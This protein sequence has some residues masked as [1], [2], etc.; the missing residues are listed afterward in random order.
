MSLSG[1]LAEERRARLAA[2]RLLEQ[3]QAE[4]FAANRKLGQHARLL[5]EQ[6]VETRAEVATVRDENQRVKS[7]LTKANEKIAIVE[8][9][10]WRALESVRDGFA[11]FNADG[12]LELANPAYLSVFDGVE[13][14][15]PGASFA[16]IVDVMIEEGIVDLRGESPLAWRERLLG[17]WDREDIPPEII[18]LWNG[19]FVKLMDRRTPDGG[20]V[21]LAVNITELMRMWSAVEELPDGFVV[22]DAEDRLVTCNARYREL[23]AESAEAMVPGASFEE[24]LRHGLA[25]RQFAEALGRE[26]AWLEERLE[27]HRAAETAI[28][29]QLADGRWLRI[30][31]KETSDGGRV[32]LRVDITHL[33]EQQKA[34]EQA[35]ERAEAANR[36]KSAFL[37]NMTHEIRTPMNGVVGMA[38]LLANTGLTEDQALYVETIRT[39]GES[40]LVII[41][42]VLDYSKIEADKLSLHP[43]PFDLERCIH[44]IVMLLQPTARD[45]GLV[46]LVDYDLFLPTRFVGDPGRIR[47]VLTNLIGN[48]VKFTADGHVL[49]RVTGLPD[50]DSGSAE[51]IVTV[52]DT[53][54]GIAADRQEHIFGEFNQVE[55]ACNRSFEG[56]GLGLA[57]TRR[58]IDLM[59][60]QIWVE[61]EEGA[62]ACFGFRVPLPAAEPLPEAPMGPPAMRTALVVDDH[63]ANREILQKQL[64]ALGMEVRCA[65]SAEVAMTLMDPPPDV[66]LTDHLMPGT[67]GVAFARQ[68][69]SGGRAMPILLLSS[70]PAFV[71]A[72]LENGLLQ[73]ILQKPVPRQEL[74]RRLHALGGV[75]TEAPG[76]GPP[77]AEAPPVEVRQMRVLLAE[78]NRTNQLVFGKMVQGLDIDLAFAAN[79]LEAVAA[80]AAGPPDLIFMDISMPKMDGRAAARE[81]R[82]QEA[83][84][85]GR[86]PIV[87]VTAHAMEGD[88]QAILADGID[89]YISKPVRKAALAETIRAH[90][91][92]GTRPPDPSDPE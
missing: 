60:G 27:Q 36:A 63:P 66:V 33:K 44:E 1:K 6:I 89:H 13:T 91:P 88:C 16:H 3:K 69:R 10:L 71:E 41:N 31:E 73:A 46:M 55:D 62:G 48:A 17:R 79:G 34:L 2:E 53:G 19:Q 84:R 83:V 43:E 39:S 61:S 29:L 15:A 51:V 58:L 57:I 47:Q 82:R 7:D 32:G 26:E 21:T 74:L 85:G 59:G 35:M 9:Q 65:D 14:V 18:R 22:Y 28:E 75:Q 23:Y 92:P 86:V 52:E 40:L 24:V 76:D 12:C 42:D 54:I 68:L 64:A 49:V 11:M 56:T 25:R 78:D 80:W 77:Q 4:L 81:I 90:R 45:K 50:S 70:N 5:S 30:F 20:F 8:T 87:A 37:A 38:E 72:G 67:D